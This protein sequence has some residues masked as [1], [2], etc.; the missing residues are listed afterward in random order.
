MERM[1]QSSPRAAAFARLSALAARPDGRRITQLFAA[2]AERARR[3]SASF[4]DLTLD[5]SK[6]A[7]DDEALQA[8]FALADAADL[9]GFR[10]RL[11]AGEPVNATEHRA[12]MHMALRSPPGSGLRAA[13]SGGIDNAT[14]LA[15]AERNRM[16]AF[17]AAAHD[18]G[19]RGATGERFT[20]VVNIGIGG[21]DLGPLMAAQALTLGRTDAKLRAHFLS[22]VDG[23]AFA[24]TVQ[25][26]DP[27]R[28]LVLV[29]SKTFTTLETAT[30]A[31]AAR[32]WLAG[33][34]GDAAVGKHFAALSTNLKAVSAFGIQPEHVFGFRD[35]VGGRYSLWSPIGLSIA[36]AAGWDKF[37]AMLDGAWAMDCHFRDTP[38][39]QNLPVLL[40]LAG[41]WNVDALGCATH[42]VLAYD[43]RLKRFPAFLQQLEMESNGKH[44]MLTG[45]QVGWDTCPIV[46]GEPGTNAQHSFMQLVHQ[47]T[48]VVPVDFILAAEPD[49][50]RPAAHRALAANAF[51]QAEALLRGRSEAEIRAEMTAHGASPE[52]ID[53]VAPH[54]VCTGER[55]SNFIMFHRLD[56]FSL[57]RLIALYEHKVAVQGCLWGIDSF[58]QWG[59]ELGKQL[60][61]GILPELEPGVVP[62]AHDS[63]TTGLITRFRGLRGEA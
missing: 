55:P 51:A 42:C 45:E 23:H 50:D 24:E 53:A 30:N 58:D 8:L 7:I 17:V 14:D 63:S 60:A 11:F 41:V 13:L 46:F 16:Q 56:A 32:A 21:S 26:L 59:V 12:A 5:I 10:K 1:T 62:G 9:E 48:R 54:R 37:Q 39:R 2:S 43:E 47:G 31:A 44:V 33:A 61:G 25:Q 49:H 35:W 22:N 15:V 52:E 29:A 4:D 27:A 38:L 34:L 20:D 6:S 57:G 40:A 18:G 28:T 3:F 36:L 19:K